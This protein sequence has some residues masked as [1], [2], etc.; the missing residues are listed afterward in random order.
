MA[1]TKSQ[2]REDRI[3]GEIVVDA[4]GPEERAMGWYYYLDDVM[5]FPFTAVCNAQRPT[6]PLKKGDEIEILT[7]ADTDDCLHE[8]FV[9][10]RWEVNGRLAVPLAQLTPTARTDDAT[11]QA[12]EDWHYWVQQGYEF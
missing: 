9:M 10:V 4:Y 12:V 3:E 5:K 6:S 11:K 1:K 8:V 2:Q 7:L